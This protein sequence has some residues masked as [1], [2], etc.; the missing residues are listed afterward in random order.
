MQDRL[1]HCERVSGITL[2]TPERSYGGESRREHQCRVAIRAK[3]TR[4]WVWLHLTTV[5][6]VSIDTSQVHVYVDET[7]HEPITSDIDVSWRWLMGQ[8]RRRSGRKQAHNSAVRD[9][10]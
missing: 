4:L 8:T 6:I 3:H 5:R 1:L 9:H 10:D 2:A 7:G